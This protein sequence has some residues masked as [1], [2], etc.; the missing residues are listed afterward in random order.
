MKKRHIQKLLVLSL[1][2]WTLFNIPLVLLVQSTAS[3]L[4]FPMFYVY[5]FSIWLGSIIVSFIIINK[6]NE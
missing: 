5:L 4:G 1:A 6:N 3:F 2:L